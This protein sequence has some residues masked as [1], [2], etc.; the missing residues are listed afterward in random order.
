MDIFKLQNWVREDR[1]A[2]LKRS[3]A[4]PLGNQGFEE[5]LSKAQALFDR[6]GAESSDDALPH[7]IVSFDA[8]APEPLPPLPTSPRAVPSQKAI[9]MEA[10]ELLRL[11]HA[12]D[13]TGFGYLTTAVFK[14]L[15]QQ[16]V[17]GAFTDSELD[18]ALRSTT[19]VI[20]PGS[21]SA[22]E[23]IDFVTFAAVEQY[24]NFMKA[25]H[26]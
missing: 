8:Q 18:T 21:A 10:D 23:Y 15:L 5:E 9:D 4:G 14:K 20:V 16:V 25:A 11:C 12:N 19:G 22:P 26:F 24:R 13:S 6:L 1:E 3:Q 7:E 17:K 2:E